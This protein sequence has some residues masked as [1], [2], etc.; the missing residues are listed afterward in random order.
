[1]HS[2]DHLVSS[3]WENTCTGMTYTM[4]SNNYDAFNGPFSIFLMGE[5]QY[6]YDK[7]NGV[8]QLY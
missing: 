4:V 7:Y 2:M 3:S 6:K 8:Q 1:M 5:R